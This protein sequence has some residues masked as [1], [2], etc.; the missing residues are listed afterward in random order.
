MA[1]PLLNEVQSNLQVEISNLKYL[2][3]KKNVL[4]TIVAFAG[5]ALMFT[6]C[7]K[8]PEMEITNA[9]AAVEAA[10]SC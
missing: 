1:R 2:K 9:K 5:M 3:M 10:K 8:L 7:A 4:L 6:S